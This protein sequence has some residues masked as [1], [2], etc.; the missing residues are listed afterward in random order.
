M[1]DSLS[2]KLVISSDFRIS[3]TSLV[4][5]KNIISLNQRSTRLPDRTILRSH[6]VIS[7][8]SPA[9]SLLHQIKQV[10]NEKAIDSF[11][12][13]K[14]ATEESPRNGADDAQPGDQ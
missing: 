1:P 7:R 10:T 8:G 14:T 2:L 12:K 13:G 11:S 4:S 9:I 5:S 3:A 6:S